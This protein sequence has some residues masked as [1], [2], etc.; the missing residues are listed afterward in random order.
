M[1]KKFYETEFLKAAK[2]GELAKVKLYLES[3]MDI[4][5]KGAFGDTALILAAYD[6]HY[7]TASFLL[8]QGANVNVQNDDGDTP[9]ISCVLA[10]SSCEK[11]DDNRLSVI[12]LLLENNADTGMVEKNN[13]TALDYARDNDLD[14]IVDLLSSNYQASFFEQQKLS[15]SIN[16]ETVSDDGDLKF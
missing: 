8:R 10:L 12:K 15:E 1:N 9:L 13:L 3:G 2:N 14:S 16:N 6:E 7:E 11:V 4:E 5:T